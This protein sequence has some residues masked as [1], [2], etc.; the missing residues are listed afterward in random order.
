MLRKFVHLVWQSLAFSG[1]VY[2][3]KCIHIPRMH[4]CWHGCF[5]GLLNYIVPHLEHAVCEC[6]RSWMILVG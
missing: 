4:E 2:G 5:V 6:F 1:H 3:S